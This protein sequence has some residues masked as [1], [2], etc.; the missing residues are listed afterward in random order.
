MS[1]NISSC[2]CINILDLWNSVSWTWRQHNTMA[3]QPALSPHICYAPVCAC[4]WKDWGDWGSPETVPTDK[5]KLTFC[6]FLFHAQTA[7]LCMKGIWK[8]KKKPIRTSLSFYSWKWSLKSNV[9]PCDIQLCF[10]C[11]T[12]SWYIS[13]PFFFFHFGI[14]Y[15]FCCYS[16]NR[17]HCRA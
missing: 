11:L 1:A 10:S 6:W 13:D 5:R 4:S 2:M 17:K 9:C 7:T 16:A 3:T 8:C 14:M 12:T 15:I